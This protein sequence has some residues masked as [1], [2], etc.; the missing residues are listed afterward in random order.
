MTACTNKCCAS[1]L[2]LE[3]AN[4]FD[5]CLSKWDIVVLSPRVFQD[6]LSI[7]DSCDC[8]HCVY[9]DDPSTLFVSSFLFEQRTSF[10][11]YL[12]LPGT[13]YIIAAVSFLQSIH[14][15]EIIPSFQARRSCTWTHVLFQRYTCQVPHGVI[16]HQLSTTS[17]DWKVCSAKSIL[18]SQRSSETPSASWTSTRELGVQYTSSLSPEVGA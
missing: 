2:T 9:V 14:S 8:R 5:L 15:L 13:G 12:S 18:L 7:Y 10:S 6:P 1:L 17:I 11:Q 16:S 3:R 4:L